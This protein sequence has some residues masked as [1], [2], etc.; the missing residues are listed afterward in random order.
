MSV[1][2]CTQVAVLTPKGRGAVAVIAVAGPSASSAVGHYFLAANGRA[3][4]EQAIGRI[5]FGRWGQVDGEEVVICRRTVDV[6]E[7]HCHGGVVASA[8]IVDDLR[9]SGCRLIE[10]S[11]YL[12]DVEADPISVA[13]RRALADVTTERTAAILL[14]QY[15]GATRAAIA[16]IE[17]LAGSSEVHDR[18]RAQQLTEELLARASLGR[19]LTAPWRVVIAGQPNVGKSSLINALLGYERA[20]VVDTPGTTRDVVTALTAFDGWPVELADTAGLRATSDLVEAAGVERARVQIA[21]ADLILL[22]FDVSA[23]WSSADEALVECFPAALVVHNKIDLAE[24]S[25][26]RPA[27]LRVS[28]TT[29]Q[30][31]AEL[32]RAIVTQLVPDPPRPGDAVPFARDQVETL[33]ALQARLDINSAVQP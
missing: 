24:A 8:A 4:V 23:S 31:L 18:C 28:A 17:R 16:E 27:G 3:L 29:W 6:V 10:W 19:H 1:E 20:I 25:G 9:E 2:R 13:A 12:A 21:D 7:V 26:S 11:D 32:E 14:D 33:Q 30:G 15:R 22:V 5:V